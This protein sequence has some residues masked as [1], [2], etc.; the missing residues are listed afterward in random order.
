MYIYK[1]CSLLVN[2]YDMTNFLHLSCLFILLCVR[3][4][5]VKIWIL[6]TDSFNA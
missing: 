2:Y 1:F 5:Y 3:Q 6:T 4:G